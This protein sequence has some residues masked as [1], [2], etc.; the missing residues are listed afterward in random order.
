MSNLG[1]GQNIVL[2]LFKIRKL[3]K[4]FVSIKEHDPL[5]I[6]LDEAI[7]LIQAKIKDQANAVFHDFSDK[8]I[9]IK[10]LKGRYG[11]YISVLGKKKRNVKIPKDKEPESLTYQA[12]LELVNATTSAKK[13]K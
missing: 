8:E 9:P 1:K 12:C 7:E 3:I 5:Q 13:K 4:V 6:E 10:V 2:A 11:P